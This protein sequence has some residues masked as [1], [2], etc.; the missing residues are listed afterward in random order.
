MLPLA[1]IV[2]SAIRQAP[3]RVTRPA[4]PE[5]ARYAPVMPGASHDAAPMAEEERDFHEREIAAF[6]ASCAPPAGPEVPDGA[7]HEGPSYLLCFVNR[8]GSNLL[9]AALRETGALGTPREYLHP[10][11]FVIPLSLERG[12]R[13]LRQYVR[14]MVRSTATPNGV[15]GTKVSAG[16]LACL[17]RERI[18]PDLLPDPRY[19]YVTRR[20][21]VAQAVSFLIAAQTQRWSSEL[22][23]NGAEPAYDREAIAAHL[24]WIRESE[25]AFERFFAARGIQP[26]RFV[27]EELEGSL[28]RAVAAI[29]AAVGVPSPPEGVVARVRLRRQRT[30]VNDRFVARFLDQQGLPEPAL[31]CT[32]DVPR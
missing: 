30:A 17:W 22:A 16:Q 1:A 23:G 28:E 4:E 29:A 18:V 5:R 13:D 20:D 10:H 12:C 26:L 9:A 7:P 27:Y 31:G 19:V 24:A 15:F 21:Q 25:A 3:V 8:S 11:D 32:S 14:S 6:F 2:S